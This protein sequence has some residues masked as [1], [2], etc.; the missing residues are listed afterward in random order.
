[1]LLPGLSGVL[2]LRG[3]ELGWA[4]WLAALA[5][6]L[7]TLVLCELYKLLSRRLA[8]C[9]RPAELGPPKGA[10]RPHALSLRGE[11]IVEGKLKECSAAEVQKAKATCLPRCL[12]ETHADIAKAEEGEGEGVGMVDE[13]DSVKP[14][15]V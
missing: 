10:T 4:G 12:K 3:L 6:A 9:G 15:A 13:D 11:G 8:R 2:G 5:G 1:M 7:A 14:K